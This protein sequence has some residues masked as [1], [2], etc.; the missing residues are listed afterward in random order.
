MAAVAAGQADVAAIDCVTWAHL[1]RWRPETAGK[2]RV[3]AWTE[4]TPGLPLIT[5][6]ATTDAV[7]RA[8]AS[9]LDEVCTDPALAET[10]AML[11]LG[12]FVRVPAEA[13]GRIAELERRA[14]LAGYPVLQ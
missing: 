8:L 11:L 4:A 13:Y 6:A 5:A 1:Q 10:R 7:R 12:G 3:L 14:V 9:A 2:L